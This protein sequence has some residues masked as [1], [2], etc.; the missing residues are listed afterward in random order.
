MVCVW[1]LRPPNKPSARVLFRRPPPPPSVLRSGDDFPRDVRPLVP[2]YSRQSVLLPESSG[3]DRAPTKTCGRT[4]RLSTTP[5]SLLGIREPCGIP[6]A[7][8]RSPTS[9]RSPLYTQTS[10]TTRDHSS[11]PP[12]PPRDGPS[13]YLVESLSPGYHF[14]DDHRPPVRTVSVSFTTRLPPPLHRT[15]CLPVRS[16]RTH[17]PRRTGTSRSWSKGPPDRSGTVVG[18]NDISTCQRACFDGNR[19][20]LQSNPVTRWAF[21]TTR[22][23]RGPSSH[24]HMAEWSRGLRPWCRRSFCASHRW[25]HRTSYVSRNQSRP[26]YPG[27]LGGFGLWNLTTCRVC[28]VSTWSTHNSLGPDPCQTGPKFKGAPVTG[29][30]GSGRDSVT[31]SGHIVHVTSGEYSS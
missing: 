10:A 28:R 23:H 1:G 31:R 11:R 17:I 6:V 14:R 27:S 19:T 12:T 29:R 7:T 2:P 25:C 4:N 22:V 3:L 13:R 8:S 5:T 16:T 9:F 30:T 18:E 24:E 20:W 21:Q 26:L 15:R